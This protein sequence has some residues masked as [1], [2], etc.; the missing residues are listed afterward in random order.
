MAFAITTNLERR[1]NLEK[2]GIDY[3]VEYPF[4]EE[5]AHMAPED[6]VRDLRSVGLPASDS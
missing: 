6:F 2:I 3:L 1:N 5:T 4:T